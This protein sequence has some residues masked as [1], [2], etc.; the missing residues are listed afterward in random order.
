MASM[1]QSTRNLARRL[2]Q[3]IMDNRPEEEKQ[4]EADKI[5]DR[6]RKIKEDA[7]RKM[8][9]DRDDDVDEKRGG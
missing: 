4:S 7:E 2:L 1:R 3:D 9:E 8:Q 6:L 5:K